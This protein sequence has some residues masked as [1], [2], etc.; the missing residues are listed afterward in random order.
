MIVAVCDSNVYISAIVFGG[1]PRDV[2][3]LGEHKQIQLLVSPGLISE[4]ERVL[5]RKFEW[6]PRR[7]RRICQPLW[8]AARLVKPATGVSVCR[9][10]KDDHLLSLAMDGEARYLITGDSDLLVLSPFRS[11]Q[12]VTPAQFL[13]KKPWATR[14]RF[15]SPPKSGKRQSL[16]FAE[17]R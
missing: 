2:V 14:S 4:V 11:I 8:E 1:I 6:E 15:S 3:M 10:P 5:A 7:V 12:I 9:D 17:I 16:R 13:A